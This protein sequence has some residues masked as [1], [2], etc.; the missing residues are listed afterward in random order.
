MR[1]S[2]YTMLQ[3]AS[4]LQTSF[5]FLSCFVLISTFIKLQPQQTKMAPDQILIL[6]HIYFF[7][8]QLAACVALLYFTQPTVQ[9]QRLRLQLISAVI[10]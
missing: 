5:T 8:P 2:N 9:Q 6:L 10:N 4:V 1:N 3:I 7:Q